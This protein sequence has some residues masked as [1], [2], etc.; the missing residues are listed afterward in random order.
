MTKL[1]WFIEPQTIRGGSGQV[2]R[3]GFTPVTSGPAPAP[4]RKAKPRAVR[5]AVPCA[6]TRYDGTLFAVPPVQGARLEAHTPEKR[7]TLPKPPLGRIW[8]HLVAV[9]IPIS[10]HPTIEHEVD[11][12]DEQEGVDDEE[13]EAAEGIVVV[14]VSGA[15]T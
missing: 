6:L 2:W 7:T 3:S 13:E 14:S 5:M 12:S 9:I 8:R 10:T 1:R 11:A 4:R 15:E